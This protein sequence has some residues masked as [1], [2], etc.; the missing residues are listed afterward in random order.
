M[1]LVLAKCWCAILSMGLWCVEGHGRGKSTSQRQQER[2]SLGVLVD[3]IGAGG[4]RRGPML[5]SQWCDVGRGVDMML[6]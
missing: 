4:G 1:S 3:G 2:T 6:Y 5:E